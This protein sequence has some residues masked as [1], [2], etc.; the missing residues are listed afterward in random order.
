MLTTAALLVAAVVPE[1]I[2]EGAAETAARFVLWA[3]GI[4]IAYISHPFIRR[5][6][7]GIVS[8]N[9]W[10]ERHE[11]IILVALGESIISL[12]IGPNLQAGLP[13]TGRI[14]IASVLGVTVVAA[15]WWAYFDSI[16]IEAED[17]LRRARGPERLTLAQNAYTYLH[18]PMVFGIILFSLGLKRLLIDLADP[19]MP[20]RPE[21]G[22]VVGV[23][24]CGAI[25]YGFA[26]ACLR[27]LIA[28]RVDWLLIV[29]GVV[30]AALIPVANG[31][32]VF[33]LLAVLLVFTVGGMVLHSLQT[34]DHRRLLRRRRLEQ[35]RQLEAREAE[36]HRRH[37]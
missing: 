19:A 8:V 13:L 2:F 16:S 11:Q 37:G 26:L 7:L 1:R 30:F 3:V 18:L 31:P 27:F 17:A 29:G 23:L 15:F 5:R 32:P 6:G 12:G 22:I 33:G 34:R 9:H 36:W 28:R 35:P 21:S 4:A 25:I 14:I 20:Y 10:G 24:S